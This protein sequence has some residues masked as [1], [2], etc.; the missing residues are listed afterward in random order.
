[1]NVI[2]SFVKLFAV[3]GFIV[4]HW[5]AEATNDMTSNRRGSLALCD[6]PARRRRGSMASGQ[7]VK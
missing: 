6:G 4:K 3:P 2:V 5:A 1:M 7:A